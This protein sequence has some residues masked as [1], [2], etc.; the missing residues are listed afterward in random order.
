MLYLQPCS[1]NR[2]T[3][4]ENAV[5]L[6]KQMEKLPVTSSSLVYAMKNQFARK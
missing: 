6:I 3:L 2:E 4:Y 1:F 5:D